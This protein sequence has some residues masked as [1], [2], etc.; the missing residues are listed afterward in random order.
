[1]IK[2]IHST[3]KNKKI[4]KVS[5]S[6]SKSYVK[7]YED[8]FGELMGLGLTPRWRLAAD[9]TPIASV[10]PGKVMAVARVL[11]DATKEKVRYLNGNKTDLRRENLILDARG[12]NG[13]I[14]ARDLLAQGLSTEGLKKLDVKHAYKPSHESAK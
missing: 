10:L 11:L 14:R 3:D 8:D 4:V 12:G 1:V 9:G 5:L 13:R 7:L 6:N 2:I